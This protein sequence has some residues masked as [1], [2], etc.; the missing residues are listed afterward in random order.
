MASEI[1][2]P[3]YQQRVIFV[4]LLLSM[5]LYAIGTAIVLQFN[6]GEGL[7]SEPMAELNPIGIAF[8]L[9]SGMTAITLRMRLGARAETLEGAARSN[10]RYMSRLIPL[11]IIEGG[12]LLN[13]TA[14]L[15]NGEALPSLAIALVLLAV[16]ITI[17]PL[18]DP[19]ARY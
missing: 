13:I 6:D 5:T 19:D 4:A 15:I 18:N 3:F 10:A 2:I 14:W 8:G 7:A 12:C 1:T 11:V 16:A 17:T 9:V